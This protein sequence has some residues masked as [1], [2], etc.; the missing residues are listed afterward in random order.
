MTAGLENKLMLLLG[1]LMLAC[2]VPS[3]AMALDKLESATDLDQASLVG[4]FIGD[5]HYPDNAE[6]TE[7]LA[8]CCPSDDRLGSI[9][10][11]LDAPQQ[12]ALCIYDQQGQV[13]APLVDATLVGGSHQT[14]WDGC[15]KDGQDA[16][17]GTY[18]LMMKTD[19]SVFLKRMVLDR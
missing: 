18:F 5:H 17:D 9:A 4:A 15:R 3:A 14:W 1:A 16:P 7:L 10:Y 12:V 13:I 2:M 11:S 19:E 8:V 6:K